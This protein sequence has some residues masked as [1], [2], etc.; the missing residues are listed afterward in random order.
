MRRGRWET[1]R[2]SREKEAGTGSVR[3]HR[4]GRG[5]RSY[6]TELLTS[7]FGPSWFTTGR[8]KMKFISPVPA[9]ESI[10][11]RGVV[12]GESREAD[13]TR[14]ELEIWVENAAGKM[15][16]AGWASGK[17]E[18]KIAMRLGIHCRLWTTG[19]S[20]ANLDLIDH[21]KAL[22]FSVFEHLNESDR[23][24]L[25]RGNID[26][27]S[28][29]TALKEIGYAGVGSIESCGASSPE[30]RDLEREEGIRRAR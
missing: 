3:E 2:D 28:L 20:S 24:T 10:S 11:A 25:G 1:G 7:F 29:F 26:W 8:E 21:A 5:L 18:S 9:G 22:G 4:V 14:L 23:G 27:V 13:G 16:A 30:L 12:T 6:P 17:L 19:W 15:A